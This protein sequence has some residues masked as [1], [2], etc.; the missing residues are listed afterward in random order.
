MMEFRYEENGGEF[1]LTTW[2]GNKKTHITRPVEHMAQWLK[3]VL[4]VATVGGHIAMT[5]NPPPE[6]LL[7]FDTDDKYNLIDFINLKEGL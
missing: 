7:Y 6:K 2:S 1:M 5:H 3:D 4:A